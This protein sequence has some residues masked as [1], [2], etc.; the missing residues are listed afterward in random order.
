MKSAKILAFSMKN[1]GFDSFQSHFFGFVVNITYEN[2]IEVRSWNQTASGTRHEVTSIAYDT[3]DS[4]AQPEG[5]IAARWHHEFS[6]A[7]FLAGST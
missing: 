7:Y 4:H 1:G 2:W 3:A 6:P 5:T